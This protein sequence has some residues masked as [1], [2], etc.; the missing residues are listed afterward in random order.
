MSNFLRVVLIA[1]VLVG[2]AACGGAAADG[3]FVFDWDAENLFYDQNLTMASAWA[4]TAL[5][6]IIRE[7]RQTTPGVTLVGNG[8]IFRDDFEAARLQAGMEIMAGTAPVLIGADLVDHLNP[9]TI[10][11]FADWLPIMRSDPRFNEDEWFMEALHAL[12][13]DGRLIAFPGSISYE[14]VVT[15]S[16]VPGLV[17]AVG[18]RDTISMTDMMELYNTFNADG[19]FYL[20]R[21]FD[22]LFAVES[23][24]GRFFDF[25]TGYVNFNNQYFINFITAARSMT[26]PARVFGDRATYPWVDNDNIREVDAQASNTYLFMLTTPFHIHHFGAFDEE[27]V[28]TN[29]LLFANEDG[30]VLIRPSY[31]RAFLLNASATTDEKALAWDFIRVMFNPQYENRVAHIFLHPVNNQWLR[32]QAGRELMVPINRLYPVIRGWR[33]LGDAAFLTDTLL[34]NY[35]RMASMPLASAVY[36]PDTVKAAVYEILEQFHNGLITAEAAAND[37]Q[38]RITLMMME[39]GAISR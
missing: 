6:S 1:A 31:G 37:L 25:E 9:L 16:S 35:D 12:S 4:H 23:A 19:S 22:V 5:G 33:P 15:N 3:E 14:Y 7:H 18:N 36:A 24:I 8:S 13:V 39:M 34:Q 29:P 11:N 27:F 30:Q 28:F 10:T 2:F 32:S 21:R 17:D 38:N 26:G 20:M